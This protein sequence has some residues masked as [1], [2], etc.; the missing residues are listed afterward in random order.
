MRNR[1]ALLAAGS[2]MLLTV[3][4]CPN[5]RAQQ[6]NAGRAEQNPTAGQQRDQASTETQTIRGVIAGITAEG[7]A[8]FDYKTNRAVAAE[9]GYLTV[10][11]S[12]TNANAGDANR[13]ANAASEDRGS[14]NRRRH[15]VYYVWLTPRTK[16]CEADAQADKT[17]AQA[18]TQRSDQ[19]REIAFD[20]LEVGDHV[21]IQFALRE[22]S[23]SAPAHQTD[24]L[25]KKHG[26]H[27]THVG[28]ASEIKVLSSP[29]TGS[30]G[31][32]RDNKEKSGSQ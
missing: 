19:K 9:A 14:S 12:P 18:D 10:V 4:I 2:A 32:E 20:N 22:D 13:N 17:N 29:E 31:T 27:R 16:I 15:N 30:R 24:Q 6:E 3:A 26:R 23:G 5:A 11:G 8:M 1:L 21:E 25:R 7:E 28:Y